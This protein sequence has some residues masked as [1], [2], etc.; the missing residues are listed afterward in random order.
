MVLQG[1]GSPNN[2]RKLRRGETLMDRRQITR[3][4]VGEPRSASFFGLP[5]S[6][7]DHPIHQQRHK[8]PNFRGVRLLE[9]AGS[10]GLDSIAETACLSLQSLLNRERF[11]L[12]RPAGRDLA[13]CRDQRFPARSFG[14]R[15]G[16]ETS[17]PKH[18]ADSGSSEYWSDY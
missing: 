14:L 5:I 3:R 11:M 6:R 7:I 1:S 13:A 15:S 12:V 2:L 18:L 17:K 4:E 8:S 16:Q 10:R 9:T